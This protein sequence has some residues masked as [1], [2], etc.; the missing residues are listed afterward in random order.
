MIVAMALY[1]VWFTVDNKRGLKREDE[2]LR[3]LQG[4]GVVPTGDKVDSE[5]RG[6]E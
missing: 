5:K 6:A 3:A 2:R 1:V 4:Q